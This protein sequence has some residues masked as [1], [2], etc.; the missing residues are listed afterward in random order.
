MPYINLTTSNT[1][2]DDI[3]TKLKEALGSIITT[4]PGK[5]EDW[6]MIGIKD[7]HDLYF[8]GERCE[9]AA[10]VEVKIYGTADRKYKDAMTGKICDLLNQELSI[11]KQQI[12]VIYSDVMDWG[13]NG[14]NF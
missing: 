6:L 8:R 14:R 4:I 9:K 13:W 1:L 11:P 7:G 5:S 10:V 3:K 12:Y 2:N